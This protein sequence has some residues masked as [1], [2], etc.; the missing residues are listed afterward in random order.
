[1]RRVLRRANTQKGKKSARL[2]KPVIAR[3]HDRLR[4]RPDAELVEQ[5][6]RVIAHGLLADLQTRRNIRIA[7]TVADER[8]D[9]ALTLRQAR[10]DRGASRVLGSRKLQY[11]LLESAP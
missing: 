6:R 5:I 1:M 10:K 9:F 11:R 8:Q 2:A 4:A 7:E 3:E